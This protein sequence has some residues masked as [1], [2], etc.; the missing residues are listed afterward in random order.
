MG[1]GSLADVGL[2][3]ARQEAERWRAL[4]RQGKDPI[5]ER[6]RLKRQATRQDVTFASVAQAAFEARKADLKG[7][8]TAGRWYS[9]LELHVVPKLGKVPIEEIN[10]LDLKNVLA[11][12]WH[13]KG[14]TARK[15]LVRTSIVFRHAAAMGLNVDLQAPNKARE[16]LGTSRQK[17]KNIPA[18]AWQEVPA[19]YR[20][21]KHDTLT[22]LAIRLLI[23][24][25]VRSGS[26]RL[27]R[28]EQFSDD[29]WEI[30]AENMKGP[31]HK[32]LPFRVPLSS[33]AA[34]T[35]NKLRGF[36]REGYLFP[37]RR[38]GVISDM[39]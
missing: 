17:T 25:A 2:K 34:R 26:L 28:W 32:T 7:D 12:I 21:L 39:T 14:E 22:V 9:P 1:L 10:Q 6:E 24:T 33:E 15:A 36:E 4:V 19:F 30:P 5:K 3:E 23:L 8:G 11:P 31:I 27:A 20:S 37:G 38:R 16:L 29:T 18:L 13:E 35:L